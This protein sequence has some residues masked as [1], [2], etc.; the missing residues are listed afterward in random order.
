MISGRLR[1]ARP[2]RSCQNLYDAIVYAKTQAPANEGPFLAPFPLTLACVLAALAALALPVALVHVPPLLDYPN[3]FARL[4]LLAGG[5]EQPPISAMYA[6]DWSVALTN[7]GVDLIAA[8]LGRVIGADLLG[9][10]LV[11]AALILPP[12][13]AILLNCAVFGGWHWWQVG[14]P[15][16]AWNST[17]LAGFA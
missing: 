7:I 10:L 1:K 3:H 11:A 5:I 17:L 14:F 16:L 6:A 9:H 8:T 2:C 4:W 15:I 13:G 12:L